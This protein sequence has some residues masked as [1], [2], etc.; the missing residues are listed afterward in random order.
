MNTI[1]GNHRQSFSDDG[2]LLAAYL[3][4]QS[5]DDSIIGREKV[6]FTTLSYAATKVRVID[7]ILLTYLRGMLNFAVT[8]ICDLA[9]EGL[10][11]K[12]DNRP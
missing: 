1:L 7:R 5:F 3:P 4:G 8:S 10:A 6:P 2:L 11:I 9:L 12:T